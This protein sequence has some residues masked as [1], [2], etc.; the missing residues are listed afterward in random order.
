M[1]A[2]VQ[3]DDAVVGSVGDRF[4]H[5]SKV[6]TLGSFREIW[7]GGYWKSDIGENLVVIGPCW[8][9]EVDGG[10]TWVEFGDEQSS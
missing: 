1:G 10:V 8:V 7:V 4:L 5:A 6:K 2:G 3:Q 9:A